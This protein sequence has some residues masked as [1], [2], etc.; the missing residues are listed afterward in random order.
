[1]TSKA[2]LLG[3]DAFM[4]LP[5]YWVLMT[6]RVLYFFQFKYENFTFLKA[7]GILMLMAVRI[8]S[9]CIRIVFWAAST[10][11][12]RLQETNIQPVVKE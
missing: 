2:E 8:P 4:L 5:E 1:M 7:G 3:R 12:A 6:E 11:P 9:I 10:M